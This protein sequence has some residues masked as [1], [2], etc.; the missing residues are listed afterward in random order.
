MHYEKEVWHDAVR[1]L[2]QTLQSAGISK[3][4]AALRWLS[5]HSQLGPE[6]G[7]ILG[8]SKL[9]YLDLNV[10]AIQK[11]PLPE[12]IV[13]SMDKLCIAASAR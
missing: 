10:T 1:S 11:G 13:A 12:S 6:D 8:A 3:I 4:E 7:I 5:F 9:E 2:D